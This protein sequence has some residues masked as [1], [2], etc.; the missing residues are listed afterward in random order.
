M[1]E[2]VPLVRPPVDLRHSQLNLGNV[3]NRMP[4]SVECPVPIW[5]H[6]RA[7]REESQLCWRFYA[8]SFIWW[9]G[10]KNILWNTMN[11]SI[12]NWKTPR[13]WS[14]SLAQAFRIKQREKWKYPYPFACRC[15]GNRINL[16]LNKSKTKKPAK[17]RKLSVKATL[18]IAI[19]PFL[20]GNKTISSLLIS[21][22]LQ[23]RQAFRN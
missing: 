2:S 21:G 13:A 12:I 11:F 5:W 1:S 22:Y 16:E 10:C 20:P 9:Q 3:N 14:L 7:G 15:Q 4:T 19:T 23:L 6:V 8:L 18:L 17:Q